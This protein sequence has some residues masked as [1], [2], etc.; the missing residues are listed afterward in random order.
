MTQ[1]HTGIV[2]R[3]L[4]LVTI[5]KGYEP[6]KRPSFRIVSFCFIIFNF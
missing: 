2:T 5:I 6:K 1:S 3:H 4:S